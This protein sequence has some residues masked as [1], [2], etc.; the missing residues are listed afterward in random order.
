MA[1]PDAEGSEKLQPQKRSLG[2]PKRH[3]HTRQWH[4]PAASGR[5]PDRRLKTAS[6]PARIGSLLHPRPGPRRAGTET[7]AKRKTPSPAHQYPE[8]RVADRTLTRAPA[9]ALKPVAS[10]NGRY[11]VRQFDLGLL[12]PL[13]RRLNTKF[14]VATGVESSRLH[15]DL[16]DPFLPLVF[17]NLQ[18]NVGGAQRIGL[19]Y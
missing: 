7:A 1:K 19:Y 3:P 4:P 8:T 6:T 10:A 16:Q 17:H 15:M 13:L 11:S 12:F 14:R 18:R 2:R 5:A 9:S